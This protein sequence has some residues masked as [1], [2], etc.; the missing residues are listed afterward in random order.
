[1]HSFFATSRW[2]P[3]VIGGLVT[4]TA[5]SA[6]AA[7]PAQPTAST[8]AKV[9]EPTTAPAAAKPAEPA[10]AKAPEPASAKPAVTSLGQLVVAIPSQSLGFSPVIIADKK[11]FFKE[12]G[13]DVEIVN[14][15]SGSKAAAAVV[16]NSAQLG[17]T[18]L[19]DVVS[20]VEKGQDLKTIASFT[21]RPT[22][23]V[24]V[25][26]SV[27]ERLGINDSMPAADR[28]R[29]LKGLKLAIST[30][31]SGTDT[32]LRY[33]LAA[34]GV[35]PERDVEILTTGSVVNSLAAYA[36]GVADGA[37]L[38]S[39]STET[40]LLQNDAVP[41]ILTGNGEVPALRDQ[42][43][44]G[45]WGTGKWLDANP[46][47]AAAA[48][49]AIWK[50]LNFIRTNEQEASELIRREAWA[51]T[52][53]KV[54]ELAWK[55]QMQAFTDDPAITDERALSLTNYI[56]TIEKREV[57]VTA[58]LLSTNRF[59]EMVRPEMAR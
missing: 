52:D 6:P 43:Q 20:A 24:V 46:D 23:G 37:S 26:R 40:A 39:P 5:C 14:A 38:S 22:T 59:V 34:H 2:I 30:P 8:A 10:A 45:M 33:L 35:D 44:T 55:N 36:Q 13:L 27:A 31:G 41:V 28:I 29:A 49:K 50:S 4:L 11:G 57:K 17:A 15:G 1:M 58:Q 9:A 12:S 32:M 53:P 48:T 3:A 47:K 54:F 7:P 56:G 25:R 51:E 19:A 16:G 42:L 18:D 21:T